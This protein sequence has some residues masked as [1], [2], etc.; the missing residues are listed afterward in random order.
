MEKSALLE[1]FKVKY[2]RILKEKNQLLR[3]I[4]QENTKYCFWHNQITLIFAVNNHHSKPFSEFL[5]G[6]ASTSDIHNFSGERKPNIPMTNVKTT[7]FCI[8]YL[9]LFFSI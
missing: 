8:Y 5:M 3:K 6:K 4:P 1:Y 2:M 7:L 9:A